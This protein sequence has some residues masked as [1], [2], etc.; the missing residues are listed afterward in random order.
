[1]PSFII[2]LWYASQLGTILEEHDDY[3]IIQSSTSLSN[4]PQNIK[5]GKNKGELFLVVSKMDIK[6][7]M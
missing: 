5:E 4:L 6:A 2:C 3:F 7:F 1:M